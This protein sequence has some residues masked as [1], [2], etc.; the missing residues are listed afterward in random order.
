MV[1]H[2]NWNYSGV[3]ELLAWSMSKGDVYLYIIFLSEIS[4]IPGDK[5]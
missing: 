4:S 1:A 2:L 3:D 5:S